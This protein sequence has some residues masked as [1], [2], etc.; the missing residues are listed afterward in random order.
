MLIIVRIGTGARDL[1]CQGAP[2]RKASTHKYVAI[3]IG[4]FCGLTERPGHTRRG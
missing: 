4:V 1:A 3:A 2:A